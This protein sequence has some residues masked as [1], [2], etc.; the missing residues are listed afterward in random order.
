MKK[1]VSL[2]LI[3]CLLV[4]FFAFSAGAEGV[5]QPDVRTVYEEDHTQNTTLE[6]LTAGNQTVTY[7]GKS[8]LGNLYDQTVVGSGYP[9]FSAQFA[10]TGKKLAIQ[11]NHASETT[12]KNVFSMSN[13]QN[14]NAGQGFLTVVPKEAVAG[15]DNFTVNYLERQYEPNG[16]F[17]LALFYRNAIT[18]DGIDYFGGY[19]NYSFTGFTG[20]KFDTYTA[21]TL[22]NGTKTEATCAEMTTKPAKNK[23]VF[24]SVKCTKGSWEVNN[25]TYTA[26][27]ESYVDDYLI[28]T[29]YGLWAD[30]PIMFYYETPADSRWDVQFTNIEVTT[31]NAHL[32][33]GDSKDTG[34]VY[35]GC[36]ESI[37]NTDGR[38]SVRFVATVESLE[39]SAVGFEI[40][41][42]YE[43]GEI[44]SKTYGKPMTSVCTGLLATYDD[45]T[46]VL[47]NAEAL[48]G[49]YLMAYSVNG[50]PLSVGTATFT[51]TPWYELAGERTR[52]ASYTVIYRDGVLVSQTAVPEI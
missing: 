7:D 6:L 14:A 12:S 52:G 10:V 24:V 17:G 29:S 40:E 15:L 16:T 11:G 47:V 46:T 19:D 28:A 35:K 3:L 22:E 44:A 48:G 43:A 37:G 38:F 2:I 34:V 32:Q 50:I 9:T 18:E 42:V 25:T 4:P 41:A 30:A 31:E 8:P 45:D 20:T 26:K 33:T 39:Y 49:N 21:F 1:T 13:D 51:V 23:S 36:Q 27:I 5:Y